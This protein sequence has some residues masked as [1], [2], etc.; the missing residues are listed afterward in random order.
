MPHLVPSDDPLRAALH[1]VRA[2]ILDADGVLVL[3]GRP[4]PGAEDALRRLSSLGIPYR[5]VTNY[6]SA[7][8]STLA[9]R[10]GA[11]GM[12][13]DPARMITG[14]SSAATYTAGAYPG[15]PLLVLGAPDA[16]REFE[17]QR[18]VGPAEADAI[19]AGDD[20]TPVAGVA[21]VVIGDAGEDLSFANLD[22]A[23]RLVRGGAELVAM[24][25]NPWWLTP[26]G[27][28][29][30][31]GA[32]VKGLEWALGRRARVTGKPSP[33]VFRQAAAGLAA[34][35]GLDRL[36]AGVIA[37]VGDDVRADLAP[38]GRL[39]MRTVLV[40]TGK[41]APEGIDAAVGKA[42]FTPDAIAPSVAEVAAALGS[43]A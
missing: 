33:L 40:L 28:T 41:T 30:D 42:R 11:A 34:D 1:G 25:R 20:A 7:H 24:H 31:S 18:V 15:R 2:L 32:L 39:G 38:A 26:R 35:L 17:G 8:R 6:S 29:L 36:P 3:R 12:A 19:G 13:V 4:V 10:F 22:I 5:V 16:L 14:A 9:E 43:K 27:V 37:M 21:A 23:F